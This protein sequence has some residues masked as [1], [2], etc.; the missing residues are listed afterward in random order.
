MQS[1]KS[2]HAATHSYYVLYCKVNIEGDTLRYADFKS[3]KYS[4]LHGSNVEWLEVVNRMQLEFVLKTKMSGPE[5][6]R[7]YSFRVDTCATIPALEMHVYTMPRMACLICVHN[8]RAPS[9]MTAHVAYVRVCCAPVTYLPVYLPGH[10]RRRA[11][12]AHWMSGLEQ[13]LGSLSEEPIPAQFQQMNTL[14]N[15]NTP[16]LEAS[17]NLNTPSLR[18]VLMS[19]P[20]LRP[21]ITARAAPSPARIAVRGNE[22]GLASKTLA[23]AWRFVSRK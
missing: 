8:F 12:F 14:D 4:V 1:A 23:F 13:W 18:P 11:E 9:Y 2:H 16:T 6:G 22:R 20:P 19:D 3:D 17:V 5:R 10:V 21:S 15:L 7:S